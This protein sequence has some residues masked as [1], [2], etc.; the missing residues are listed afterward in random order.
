MNGNR[1]PLLALT[2]STLV[3]ACLL[4]TQSFA[5]D[6]APPGPIADTKVTESYVR[7][8]AREAYFWGWPMANIFNRRQT[9]KDLPEPGLMGGIV[10][11]APINHLSLLSDY[12]DPAERLV[13]C[14]NQDV[15]YGAGSIA[16]D[17]EP[18]IIQVP[19]FGNRFWVY[20]VVDLRSD[21]F[22]ELGKMYGT[23]PGF[24]LLVGPD[25]KGKVPAGITKV[26]RAHT[27]T[28]FVIPRVFQD[29]TAGD[30]KAVQPTLAGIDMY[31]LSKYDGK[32]KRRDW[33]QLPKFPSQ[34]SGSSETKWV[35]PEKFF[36]E[37]PALL[38]DAKPL[39]GEEARY[40]Q[41]AALAAI[42]K[43]DPQLK[44]AMIDEAKKADSE[45]V[46][47]LLQFR[48]YGLQLP[49]HWSTVSNGA[50]FGTDYFTRTAVARSNIFVNQQKETK[51]FY[52]D[53]DASGTRLNG[54]NGYSVTFP[55][56][57]L[58]PVKGFWSLT[59]YNEQH[60]FSPNDLARYSIGTKNKSLKSN[61][62]G[63][64]TIYVQNESPGK[65]KE[66]NWLPAPK[67]AD[68]SLYI[69]AYWPEPAALNGQWTPP[70][71]AKAN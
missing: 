66:S 61:A 37:L 71:V 12:I 15:V 31:P 13:A 52:Q 26:F 32:V 28:G 20:Q 50:A 56:G 48:N 7:M 57:Q 58:P 65:D 10:P 29:D 39:P 41:M 70:P 44:A 46:D 2:L 21:S 64:L 62:D 27:N 40:A 9:F 18:V 30:R 60:F 54:Q 19:D 43:A 36:D 22:A 63:S 55:K 14:P 16:L 23:K 35:V 51:Y 25:W 69:R 67:G 42:A 1:R 11:V 4:T 38:K 17:L 49:H 3:A 6:M 24:Y 34:E 33:S 8:M 59:L 5:A 68:F 45:V 47:P 53:L